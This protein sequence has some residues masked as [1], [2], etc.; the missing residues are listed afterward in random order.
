M[1]NKKKFSNNP[2]QKK[3]L[4]PIKRIR[5]IISAFLQSTPNWTSTKNSKRYYKKSN[6]KNWIVKNEILNSSHKP[7]ITWIG[8]STF[9]I[10]VADFNI[11][12]DPI[13]NNATYLYPRNCAPGIPLKKLP[14][15]DF[16]IISHNHIDHMEKKSLL[17]LKKDNP[18]ILVPN[19]EEWW[20]KKNGFKNIIEKEWWQTKSFSLKNENSKNINFHFLPAVH[21]TGSHLF[22]INKSWWGSFII[23]F[24]N[25]KTYFAGDT[26]YSNHFMEISQKFPNIDLALLPIAPNGPSCVTE[27]SHI[28]A[29]QSVQA[30][31]DLKAKNFIP[32]HWGTFRMATDK[33]EEPIILL[34]DAWEKNIENLQ[35]K[36]L[37]ILKFG[38]RI[39]F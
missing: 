11:I 17:Y 4:S 39:E 27:H 21:W 16:I 18:T 13:F 14:Q 22:N 6:I 34:K 36:K 5:E 30:F 31:I 38:E 12:T 24:E 20:F 29:K 32:M 19:G 3:D 2:Y 35:D 26:A 7:A 9:L 33:F 37:H 8:H 10:Q 1:K 28:N 25:F 23:E 15:I